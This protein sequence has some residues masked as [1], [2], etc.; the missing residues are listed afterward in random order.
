MAGYNPLLLRRQLERHEGVLQTPYIDSLGNLTVGIGHLQSKRISL[1]V[2]EALYADDVTEVERGL[3]LNLPWWRTL[4]DVR[5]RVLIDMAFNLGVQRLLGFVLTLKAIKSGEYTRAAK[6][7]LAS[8][9][10]TQVGK[11]ATRLA[12]MMRTND[13]VV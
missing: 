1:P 13:D 8:K 12:T 2:L 3:D 5:Q 11:R 10:A 4:S 9:W 7:M 6:Q